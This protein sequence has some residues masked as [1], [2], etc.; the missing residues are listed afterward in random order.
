MTKWIIKQ[1]Y[2]TEIKQLSF[3]T[4]KPSISRLY[5]LGT[6]LKRGEKDGFFTFDEHYTN[7]PK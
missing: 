2:I 7:G 4:E 3:F 6:I 1:K 5:K